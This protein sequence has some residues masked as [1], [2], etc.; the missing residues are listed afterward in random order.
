MKK[1]GVSALFVIVFLFVAFS[2]GLFAGRNLNPTPIQ[3]SVLPSPTE[4]VTTQETESPG[5][6]PHGPVN[7][8]TADV[9]AL[10]ALPGIGPVIAQ[11]IVDHR[12]NHGP[13]NYPEQ[14]TE[15]EGI[16]PKTLEKLLDYITVGG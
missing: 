3:I 12:E 16:G 5:T 13:F 8:N 7:I 1:R 9:S 10:D 4:S 11:R 6:E 15:V 2:V 14:L